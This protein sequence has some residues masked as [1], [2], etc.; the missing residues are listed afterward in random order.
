M[1]L[2]SSQWQLL[3][4]N[5]QCNRPFKSW[6]SWVQVCNYATIGSNCAICIHLPHIT[7]SKWRTSKLFP[8]TQPHRHCHV[9]GAKFRWDS[10]DSCLK[11]GTCS[12]VSR[13]CYD[14]ATCYIQQHS[15]PAKMFT[16]QCGFASCLNVHPQN[17]CQCVEKL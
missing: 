6:N 7:T 11:T 17:L 15:H 5:H 8:N 14:L 16:G 13:S 9:A 2:T 3:H 1:V 4:G 12:C 10:S